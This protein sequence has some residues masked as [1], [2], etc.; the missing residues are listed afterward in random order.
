MRLVHILDGQQSR[1]YASSFL[2]P[3][4]LSLL[5]FWHAVVGFFMEPT[6]FADVS[7]DNMMAKEESFGPIMII[8]KF[9]DG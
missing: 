5:A 7:D 6:V 9:E 2:T 4:F 1:I 3:S 8:S